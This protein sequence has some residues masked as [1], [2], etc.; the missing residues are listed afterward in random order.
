MSN[1]ISDIE[2]TLP[3]LTKARA[4][5]ASIRDDVNK[6][7]TD[8]RNSIAEY[9]TKT[10]SFKLA[11][12]D[13]KQRLGVFTDTA[14]STLS[15]ANS[16]KAKIAD[17]EIELD[18]AESVLNGTTALMEKLVAI[19]PFELVPPQVV[20]KPL[21]AETKLVNIFLPSIIGIIAL[22]SSLLFPMLMTI[23]Q[24]DEGILFRYGVSATSSL[25]VLF[26]RF[27]ANY[28][29]GL[30]Q[31]MVIAAFGLVFLGVTFHDPFTLFVALA[32][33]PAVFTALGMV[34][35]LV[36]RRGSTAVLLTLL[37]AIPMIFLCGTVIPVEN[38]HGF[39][40]T[41]AKY[42]PLTNVTELLNKVTIRNL[43]L[44]YAQG[45]LLVSLS[46]VAISLAIASFLIDR[47]RY[48]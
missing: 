27:I 7:I 5:A 34:F 6:T 46:Y 2:D 21:Q 39:M 44:T 19:N 13:A 29:V 12:G 36:V 37:L 32:M 18:G 11:L 41:V 9:G 48:R 42:L 10:E 25:N 15:F 16:T 38:I 24:R 45:E 33:A 22:L 30:I 35:A 23:K 40:K 28:I 17:F 31:V 8:A 1:S 26:G 4:T 14:V 43:D 3:K 47:T 20:R